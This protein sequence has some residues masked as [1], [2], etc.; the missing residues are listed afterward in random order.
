MYLISAEA[1]KN[2]DVHFLKVRKTNEIWA[3]MKDV[4]RGMG[5]KNV[6]DLVLKKYTAFVKQKIL[7]KSKLTITK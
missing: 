7:Q 5:V 1:Y 4:G 3:S 6:C 2:A